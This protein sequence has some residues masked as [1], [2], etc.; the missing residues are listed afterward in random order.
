MRP[1]ISHILAVLFGSVLSMSIFYVYSL[2][3]F[4]PTTP[5]SST[6]TTMKRPLLK[7]SLLE[8]AKREPQAGQ[9]QLGDV[10]ATHPTYTT[11]T[12]TFTTEGKTVSGLA[13]IP[14]GEGPFPVIVQF[15]GYVDP[16]IY[17][18][19][20]GTRRSGEVYAQNGYITFAPDFLNYAQSDESQTNN[21]FEDRFLT[22]TTA[23]DMIEAAS[24][25]PKADP[26]NIAIWGHSNGGHIALTVLAITGK[27]YPTALWAPVT[28]PFP[29]S[30]LYYTDESVD[31][32]KFI[33]GE[34]ARFEGLYDVNQFTFPSYID[35]ITAP[36]QL[37]QGTA[38]DAVPVAWS[39]QFAKVLEEKGKNVEYYR[40]P[41]ADHNMAGSWDSVVQKDVAFFQK[42]QQ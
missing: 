24:T 3:S 9:I 32:G 21:I 29:Y 14:N 13:N 17:E 18:T 36:I 23:L 37:H 26:N 8:L 33:R 42:N 6:D 25:F 4:Q 19:G 39:D 12:Y 10:V 28:K 35:R 16:S 7:Y 34:L 1:W 38:D 15:R 31:Q 40:Y 5:I 2:S 30:V 20:V 11:Y 22:Y 41:G 27:P